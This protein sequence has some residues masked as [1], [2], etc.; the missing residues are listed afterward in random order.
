MSFQ[1]WGFRHGEAQ[2]LFVACE[3]IMDVLL[4]QEFAI[5]TACLNHLVLTAV[6]LHQ[7]SGKGAK[8]LAVVQSE[9]SEHAIPH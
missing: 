4:N 8:T 1:A 2:N 5:L 9:E 6:Q 3:N 7:V